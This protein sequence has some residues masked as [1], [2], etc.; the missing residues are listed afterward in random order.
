MLNTI[1]A[2]QIQREYKK[3]FERANKQNQPIMVI[4]NNKPVGA[5]ISLKLL[6]QLNRNLQLEMLEKEALAEYK[7]GGT[8][9]ITTP[10]ELRD[11]FDE[12]REE[13]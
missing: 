6:D 13:V 11:F 1:S 3:I 2:K 12:I 5:I 8:I 9:N 7:K 4:T 10:E